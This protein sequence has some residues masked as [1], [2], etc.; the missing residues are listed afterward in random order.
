MRAAEE[1]RMPVHLGSGAWRY[2]MDAD[3]AK[4]PPGW[5]FGDVAGVAVDHHDQVYAFDRGEHPVIVFDREGNFVRSWGEQVF[6]KPHGIAFGADGCLYCTDEGDHTVRKFDTHGKLLLEIGIPHRPAVP[7]SGRPFSRCTHT[8]LSPRGEIFV[9]DG[10]HNARVHKFGPDGKLIRS[11]GEA[12]AAAG[13]FNLVH[14]ISTDPDGWVY[15][16]DRENHR[17][18]VFDDDGRYETQWKNLHRPCGLCTEVRSQPVSF[19]GELGSA[20]AADGGPPRVQ[21]RVSIVD[22]CGELLAQLHTS[23]AGAERH[24]FLAPHG[25]AVDSRGDLYVAEV[26]FVGW[27]QLHPGTPPPARLCNLKKLVRQPAG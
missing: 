5:S 13:Q 20:V 7:F 12:G 21:A 18:Q 8:A 22:H 19:I 1:Q 16:A 3:W 2:R 14:N 26:G 10:Y 9:A 11:W 15:V 24:Q 23:P 6:A 4:L 25:L 17:V 27:G